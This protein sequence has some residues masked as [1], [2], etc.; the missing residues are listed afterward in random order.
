MKKLFILLLLLFSLASCDSKENNKEKHDDIGEPVIEAEKGTLENPYTIKEALDVIGTNTSYSKE[1]IYIKGI[2]EGSPYFNK[3]YSSY[4]VYLVDSTGGKSVQVYSATLDSGI[5]TKTI[6]NGDTI[7]A[8]GFYT[9]YSSKSQPELAGDTKS[10]VAYPVIYK[11]ING[12]GNSNLYETLDNDGKELKEETI[13]FNAEYQS[14]YAQREDNS[15]FWRKGDFVFENAAGK[16]RIE[17]VVT[18][19]PYRLYVQTIVYCSVTKG[20]IKY[21]EFETDSNYPFAGDEQVEHGK[22]EVVSK[23]LTRIFA[24]KGVSKIRIRNQNDIKNKKQIRVNSVKVV[25]YE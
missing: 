11:I 20:K 17:Q 10:N 15:Y 16:D 8:G 21:L 14:Q 22:V 18:N 2:V 5:N 4:S 12:S 25:Y 23:T 9:Y 19:L 1:K 13:L 6:S 3:N 7:V 24:E